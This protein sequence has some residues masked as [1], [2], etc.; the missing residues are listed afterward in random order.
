MPDT[1]VR[2]IIVDDEPSIRMSMSLVLTE[3]GY[4]VRSASDGFSALRE[5][6]HEA[7]DILLSDLNMP[8]MSGFELLSVVRHRFPAIKV[9]AMSGTFSGDEVPSGVAADAFYQKGSS[10]GS[11][12]RTIESLPRPNRMLP[13]LTETLQPIR[14]ESIG[15]DSSGEAY[16]TI[17]CPECLRTFVQPLGSSAHLL[18]ETG[19]IHCRSSIRYAIVQSE[20]QMPLR[21]FQQKPGVTMPLPQGAQ[22]LTY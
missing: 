2:L 11:L 19:C 13:M 9:I 10:I 22:N 1:Q 5:I 18:R 12:Q 17:A 20:G 7:P 6:R 15:Y 8:G 4:L 21:A 14:I 16:L 3:I